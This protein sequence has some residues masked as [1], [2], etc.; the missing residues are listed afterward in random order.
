ML[1][2]S[3]VPLTVALLLLWTQEVL[4]TVSDPLHL[5]HLGVLYPTKVKDL[6]VGWRD[7]RK[8]KT[9][10]SETP[11]SLKASCNEEDVCYQTG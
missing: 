8:E 2:W 5:L 11:S 4:Q 9:Q 6:P 3:E 7:L 1:I 10:A